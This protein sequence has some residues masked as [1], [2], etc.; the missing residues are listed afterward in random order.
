MARSASTIAWAFAGI[1]LCGAAVGATPGETSPADL[2]ATRR[3][4][5]VEI[6][7]LMKP[8]DSFTAGEPGELAA[9]QSAAR[10]I[11]AMLRATPHLFPSTT[12]RFDPSSTETPTLALPS[13]WQQWDTFVALDAA[14]VEAAAELAAAN[15]AT[16]V[17]T[18]A[19][20][21]RG[22]CDA[23]HAAFTRPYKP[24]AATDADRDFDFE[25]V[26]PQ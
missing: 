17:R 6:E 20:K 19:L 25:S 23:C 11:E 14:S 13:V 26:L 22:T 16:A 2:M 4:L 12:N 5:M 15:D 3:A 18:G 10:S 1:A 8:I 9:L 24:E 21:L 7:R